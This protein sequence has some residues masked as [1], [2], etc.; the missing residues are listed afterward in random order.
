MSLLMNLKAKSYMQEDCTL[1]AHISS[2]TLIKIKGEIEFL[3]SKGGTKTIIDLTGKKIK[4]VS[5]FNFVAF[6]SKLFI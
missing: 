3:H 4:K 1:S 6:V 5:I 2:T